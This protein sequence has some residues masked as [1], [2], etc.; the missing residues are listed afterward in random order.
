[1]VRL[2]TTNASTAATAPAIDE[3]AAT[4]T[5][6]PTQ[7]AEIGLR[8]VESSERPRRGWFRAGV[9][10]AAAA[11][12]ML[13]CLFGATPRA[14][15][16]EVWAPTGRYVYTCQPYVGC[17]YVPERA[18]VYHEHPPVYTYPQGGVVVIERDRPVIIDRR[19]DRD[20]GRGVAVG[21]AGIAV[22]CAL[23]GAC[24]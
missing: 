24:R 13:G 5:T 15:A 8:P 23:T 7:Q 17:G 19:D 20:F 6:T 1:M 3:C 22:F 12:V 16:H 2:N 21:A 14:E 9:S 11:G 4:Q 18:P 10:S